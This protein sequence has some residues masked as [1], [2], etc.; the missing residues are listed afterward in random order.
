MSSRVCGFLVLPCFTGGMGRGPRVAL[1]RWGGALPVTRPPDI[2]PGAGGAVG[3][4]DIL[5]VR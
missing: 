4:R 3:D 1:R 2:P 5:I